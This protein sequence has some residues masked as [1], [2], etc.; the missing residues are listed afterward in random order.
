M[1]KMLFIKNAAILTISS[2]ILRFVGIVFKVWLA[3]AVG[4]E[5]IGL[6]QLIFSV[7]ML[8]AT[9]VTS[10][11][12]TAVT[13]LCAEELAL[14]CANGVKKI[15]HRSICITL[16]ISLACTAV[17]FF[18]AVPIARYAVSD[19]RAVIAV[20]TLSFSLPFMGL[21]S[22]FKGY[23]IAR[24]KASPTALSQLLE[25][26]VR[27]AVVITALTRFGKHGLAFTCGAVL[28][29]DTVSEICSALYLW[30]LYL[31]DGKRIKNLSGRARPPYKIVRTVCSVMVPISSGRC[32]NSILRTVENML[33]PKGLSSYPLSGQNA[34]SQFGMIKGMA[35][36]ILFF[37]STLLSAL[38]TLLIPEI[39]E[40]A[41][42]GHRGVVREATQRIIGITSLISVIFASIFA[43]GG[44]KIGVIIYKSEDVGF[45]IKALSPIVPFMYLD[46]IC[47]GILKGLNQQKS[48]FRTSITDSVLR[49]GLVIIILPRFGIYGFIGIMYFSNLLTCILNV[50]RLLKVSGAR[51]D[52]V[53]V[54]FSPILGAASVTLLTDVVLRLLSLPNT[55]HI[56]VLCAICLPIYFLY[57][58]CT[59]SLKKEDII[60]RLR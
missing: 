45:L 59:G 41:A 33:V 31:S 24:R 13:R 5:G 15:L 25:Q 12:S 52:I 11:I 14:G 38:S 9:L 19:M 51:P 20:K 2:L 1:K 32:L 54:I 53:K 37:P 4:S 40:A 16:I 18:G 55:V 58:L 56:A 39:S 49:I 7:Y 8:A 44:E 36:P 46:G 35:L 34:L 3:A 21:S 48:S 42:R 23:F 17:L 47:D 30:I 22:C 26:A 27:I 50:G 43:V 6:Y 10:G 57:L 28:L 29:G 60:S